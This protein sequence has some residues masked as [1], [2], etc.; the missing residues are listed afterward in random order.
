MSTLD[1]VGR[2]AARRLLEVRENS[3]SRAYLC[4]LGLEAP[5]V[6]A[7]ARHLAAAGQ[8]LGDVEVVVH[9]KLV[10]GDAGLA[11]I[12][13]RKAP[14]YRNHPTA[15][16][17][18][19]VCTVPAEDV[20]DIE[21][22]LAHNSKVDDA[23]LLQ[24]EEAWSEEGLSQS[25]KE[26]QGQFAVALRGMLDANVAHDA[27]TTAEFVDR[28]SHHMV[29]DGMPPEK[30]IRAA[31]PALRLP[32]DSGDPRLK[33]T[34]SRDTAARF[35]G[36]IVDEIQP[37]LYLK[38]RDGD[39]LNR[40]E[41]RQ[42]LVTMTDDGTLLQPAAEALGALLSDRSVHDG[43]WMPTQ[44]AVAELGWEAI[45]PFFSDAKRKPKLTFGGETKE[46]FQRQFPKVLNPKDEKLLEDL[47]KDTIKPSEEVDAFFAEQR[48]RLQT[49]PRL[50]KRWEKLVFR[51]PI[52]TAD[53]GEGLLK[54]AHRAL[55]DS[56]DDGAT[57]RVLVVRL[58]KSQ[59]M[60]FWTT[61]KN[62]AILRYL[63]DRYRGLRQ[64]L[65]PHVALDFGRC[66][67]DDWEADLT[68]ENLSRL[69][70]DVELEF[71]AFLV[72]ADQ[73]DAVLADKSAKPHANRAQMTWKPAPEAIGL[74]M[75]LDLRHLRPEGSTEARLMTGKVR[76][77]RTSR[78]SSSTSVDLA[79][80]TSIIDTFGQSGG[81]LANVGR[82]ADRVDI[83]WPNS[84]ATIRE[85]GVLT[86][87]KAQ[88][89][90]DA[91]AAFHTAYGQ[92]LEDLLRG[93][94]LG[95]DSL[96]EQASRYGDLL[97]V[98]ME[99]APQEVSIRDLLAPLASIGLIEVD[100]DTT[101]ALVTAWHP[102]RLAEIAAKA[103]QLAGSIEQIVTGNA[104]QRSG[105]ED[106]VNDRVATLGATFY[107]DVAVSNA[108]EPRLLAETQAV[109]DYSLLE[110]VSSPQHGM[111]DE[112][113]DAAVKAF[114]RV[115]D[116]YL[117]LR[118]HERSNFSVVILNADSENLPLAMAN[119]LSRR[120]ED[121][122]DIRCE[123][124][125]TDDDPV[126]L[127]EVY[128]R[129]NRRISHEIDASLA[130]EAARN[131]L[132]RLRVGIFSPETLTRE[133]GLKSNDVVLLQDVIARS[134][135]VRW[136]KGEAT[137]SDEPITTFV[138]TARSK[139]RPFRK[140]NTTSALYLT[141][142]VQP[143]ACRT[144]V[145]AL[146]ALIARDVTRNVEP[147]LPI[148]EVE[149]KS[150]EV[151]EILGKA[152]SLGNWVMTFDRVADRRLI[153][154]DARRIIRYFSVPGSI[155]NVIVSTEITEEDLGDRISEDLDIILPGLDK[156]EVGTL[157]HQ[158]FTRAAQLSGGV[159]MR[160]AQWSNYAHEL[161][162]LV[163]SQRELERMLSDGR[164]SQTGWFFLDDFRDWLDL[165]GEMADILAIN[166]SV[167][168]NGPQIRVV[169]A[170]AKYVGQDKLVDQRRR[171]ASQLDSTWT[172]INHRLCGGQANLD[173]SIWRNR[174]ADMV[175]EHMDPF[176]HVG[177]ISQDAWL[178]GLRAGRFPISV[179]G[180]S[181]VF[182]HEI[183]V[184]HETM[185]HLPDE[186]KPQAQ[187]RRLA[188]W[189]F[190]RPDT[191]KALRNLGTD[192]IPSL[193]SVPT[194]WPAGDG[195]SNA[196]HTRSEPPPPDHDEHEAASALDL[197]GDG[198]SEPVS[199][200]TEPGPIESAETESEAPTTEQ[201]ELPTGPWSPQIAKILHRLSH[202]EGQADGEA[203]LE[204][205]I[206]D[207]RSALQ[208]EGMDA[209]VLG[210][211]LTPN[212]GLIYVGGKTLTVGWLERK[213]TDL[214]TRHGLDIVRITPM[215]GQIAIGLRR[216][217][218]AILH[219]ADAWLRRSE[220]YGPAQ[221]MSPLLGEK[222]D[223][224]SLCFL[225]L[226][227]EYAGQERA[228]PHSLVSGTT[229]SGKGIL[230]TNLMLDLCALNSP[231]EMELHLIDPKRGVDYAWA[232][233]LPHLAGGIIDNQDAAKALLMKLV[234]DMED[235]Y[236]EIAAEN[237][238]NID[239]FNRRVAPSR[240]MARVVIFFDEVANWMQDDDFKNVVDGLINKIATKSRA[241]GFHLF[242][243]YQRADNQV[244][245]M[246][247]RTNLG[248][249]L[250]LRLGDEG[251]SRI[252]LNEKGAER[253]LGK[254]HLIAKLDTDDKIYL[255]VPYIGDDEVEELAAAVIQ[256]WSV[257]GRIAAE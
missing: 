159:I 179:D 240:R 149:F 50:Y 115:G 228:A 12:S 17:R 105:V 91:F 46:F 122:P 54:L 226:A 190:S 114:E 68:E 33:V 180:H 113:A 93:P 166:F 185:P 218:R 90:A 131:F 99:H 246:Q 138:P 38:A 32:R 65:A 21:P 151:S 232:R 250:I 134:S 36:R 136:S 109:A 172:A 130:S 164:E 233:D 82:I 2:V 89:I 161:L 241:A 210:Q 14:Y 140:G 62:T 200:E 75:P 64:M 31:L 150:G 249:K 234:A 235:R 230:V 198:P 52:E 108:V 39:P 195:T 252:A 211:R 66:W 56:D 186:E 143:S 152:H 60:D 84:L 171:S 206:I 81:K 4:V 23:W 48:A 208:V 215:P 128:E 95:S 231:Q 191:A 98:V 42:R 119:G 83:S 214:L 204:Q 116:E 207:L 10:E 137:N 181:L 257:P 245:T 111:T 225:P 133:S 153:A 182:S 213:Q 100:G 199:T 45:E 229:G 175:L 176:D 67:D 7:I 255:Q 202:A 97:A 70:T 87:E 78:T 47:A 132:S 144:Y 248:N 13:D 28:V 178:E 20:K 170:E 254:G 102:L 217:S 192:G 74:S 3:A 55:P 63:R 15:G 184:V 19:T 76:H 73:L 169:I 189:V 18:L 72:P 256:T 125:V 127:R 5:V 219:L 221:Q 106:F 79:E 124:V 155:H 157:R 236:E 101:S 9:P 6:T 167:G 92:A 174:L 244:M 77:N 26:L 162:G 40:G 11:V 80:R 247:L 156:S 24:N 1:L 37:S 118:P 141:A 227:G 30:A 53:L 41:L 8:P 196:D 205:K 69:K 216:P 148:Q 224:G 187:R 243:V 129:Q 58:R 168:P 44:A 117:K 112:P 193:L 96:I 251:S 220:K 203:W 209:P 177:G 110:A 183:P 51:P 188:Q 29:K 212:T 120:I 103:R 57:S 238:R 123:L 154:T 25:S 146:R 135:K 163:L 61:E 22:T 34:E 27:V 104:E 85:Q 121:D 222:E 145:D 88:I 107:A 223:D 94:G 242:M 43:D 16:V 165:S 173:P 86:S 160:G 253:L 201:S 194:G 71:E 197:A 126:R 147:W 59:Q 237:C 158:L 35:F 142:P 239:Q 139:R 49:D